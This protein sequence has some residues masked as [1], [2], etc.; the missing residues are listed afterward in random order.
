MSS[1][2]TDPLAQQYENWVYPLPI[3]DLATAAPQRRDAPDPSI[4]GRFFWP[5]REPPAAPDILAAGCGA[6]Q[7]A[8]L[9]FK[10]PQAR[11][12]GIDVSQASLAHAATLK[13]RH[14]LANLELHRLPIEEVATLGRHFDVIGCTGVLHHLADPVAGARALGGVLKPDGVMAVML[15]AKHGRAGIEMVQQLFRRLGLGRDAASLAVVKET[16][17]RLPK[18]HPARALYEGATEMGYDGGLVDLFLN[19]RERSYTVPDCLALVA[20][21]GLAFQSWL[22]NSHYY[23]E[24]WFETPT[25]L[26]QRIS[27]LPEPEIWAA[28]ELALAVEIDRHFFLACRADRPASRYRPEFAGP[29]FLDQ[30]PAWA[31]DWGVGERDG[32]PGLFRGKA[33]IP[34]AEAQAGLARAIDGTRPIRVMLSVA[35]EG[36]ARDFFRVLWRAG[37]VWFRLPGR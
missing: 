20:D 3:Q 2:L 24:L 34:L 15:Y 9:A 36:F 28:M 25:Q 6:N 17:A 30:V 23:P 33:G 22:D 8:V 37:M 14:N 16:L 27:A 5:D 35:S 1:P 29:S 12:V 7:A 26:Y 11:V 32:R 18:T 21:S 13:D 31:N 19:A 4:F 10:N